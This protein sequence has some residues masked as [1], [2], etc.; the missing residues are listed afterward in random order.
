MSSTYGT[1][2]ENSTVTYEP[3][4]RG[5]RFV[6]SFCS[7]VTAESHQC[8]L[9]GLMVSHTCVSSLTR[10]LIMQWIFE[11]NRDSVTLLT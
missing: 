9:L 3:V 10:S 6:C 2:E 7:P 1:Y 4:S 5:V 11:I 8:V